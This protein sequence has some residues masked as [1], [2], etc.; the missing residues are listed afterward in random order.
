M[1]A[2]FD[3]Y[4]IAMYIANLSLQDKSTKNGYNSYHQRKR[5]GKTFLLII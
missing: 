1:T 2:L 4:A 5:G 3:V